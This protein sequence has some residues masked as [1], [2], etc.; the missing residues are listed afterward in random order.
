MFI[1]F[2]VIHILCMIIIIPTLACKIQDREKEI[3][4]LAHNLNAAE[5]R[6]YNLQIAATRLERVYSDLKKR[7]ESLEED[8]NWYKKERSVSD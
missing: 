3:N 4:I 2:M 7:T 6:I 1:F 8:N 5:D